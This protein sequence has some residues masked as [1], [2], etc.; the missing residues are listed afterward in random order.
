MVTFD[1]VVTVLLVTVTLALV[2]P[3]GTVTL[4][5]TVATDVLLLDRLTTAP[6]EGAAAVRVTVAC[7]VPP[8]TTVVGLR[9][10]DESAAVPPP[11]VTVRLAD[12]VA[13]PTMALIAT[14]VSL[15][16]VEVVTV[17]FAEV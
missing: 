6:P 2:A 7:E 17:K 15:V 4:A 11:L 8:P 16:T 3:A 1:V 10:M 5:G 13:L 12:F 14:T 9:L